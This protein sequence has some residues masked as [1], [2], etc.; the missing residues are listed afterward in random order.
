MRTTDRHARNDRIVH[1]RARGLTL[2]KIAEQVGL[3]ER[4]CARVLKERSEHRR[5][6]S[7]AARRASYS[8]ATGAE[9]LDKLQEATADL[10]AEARE[11]AGRYGVLAH[12][13]IEY[14]LRQAEEAIAELRGR[15]EVLSG[16]DRPST[17]AAGEGGAPLPEADMS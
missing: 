14:A 10:A 11:H 17:T 13:R 15:T 1:L 5:S 8:D 2:G 16:S 12:L 3:S 7:P 9:L 4:H 6:D